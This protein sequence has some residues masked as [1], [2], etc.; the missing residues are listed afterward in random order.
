MISRALASRFSALSLASRSPSAPVPAVQKTLIPQQVAV[1]L[2][3]LSS[4][5]GGGDDKS[6]KDANKPDDDPFG[7]HY[8]DG[9]ENLGQPSDLPPKY[10]R[11]RATGK[12]TGRVEEELTER[13]LRLLKGDSLDVEKVVREEWEEQWNAAVDEAGD[14]ALHAEAAKRIREEEMAL[15]TL[16]RSPRTQSVEG[17]D[18]DGNKTYQDET[19]FSK[20]LSP[21]EFRTFQKFMKDEHNIDVRQGDIPVEFTREGVP[22]EEDEG[23][24]SDNPDLDMAWLTAAARRRT[25]GDLEDDPFMDVMP[26]DFTPARRVNR[27]H[28]KTIPKELLHHNNL[29]LLRRYITPSG[30]I[31][32]RTQ[33]RLGAKDQRKIAKLIKRARNLGL[34]PHVGQ[35]KIVNEGN[36]FE[37]DIYEEREWEKELINRGLVKRQYLK[38]KQDEHE[39]V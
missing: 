16:G 8:D 30:T 3:L 18:K 5:S 28:A 17:I 21:A 10:I 1:P 15:N 23:S 2:R 11:D 22:G 34:L 19:G 38:S 24:V 25:D 6:D 14:S 35:F 31:M 13:Q 32:N 37:D 33:S 39:D 9:E 36:I 26:S 20:P 7:V 12:F 4:S 29:S 27:R